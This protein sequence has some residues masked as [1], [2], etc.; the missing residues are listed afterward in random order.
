MPGYGLF[1]VYI[2]LQ[3]CQWDASFAFYVDTITA[4][5]LSYV[6]KN[7]RKYIIFNPIA[8]I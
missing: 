4:E 5:K 2:Q 1:Y 7:L 6:S 3:N 8:D